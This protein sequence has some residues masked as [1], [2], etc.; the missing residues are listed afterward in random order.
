MHAPTGGGGYG[1]HVQPQITSTAPQV[2]VS[3]RQQQQQAAA[4]AAAS[5]HLFPLQQPV[6]WSEPASQAAVY[7]HPQYPPAHLVHRTTPMPRPT[8]PS[9]RPP[10]STST[11]SSS[12][13]S[14]C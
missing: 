12:N 3:R 11:C 14:K 7:A 4:S 5:P 8:C 6:G 9:C 1:G 10:S 2:F 13:S